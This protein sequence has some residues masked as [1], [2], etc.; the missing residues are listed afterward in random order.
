MEPLFVKIHASLGYGDEPWKITSRTSVEYDLY[1]PTTKR[2]VHLYRGHTY[3][4][5]ETKRLGFEH[6]RDTAGTLGNRLKQAKSSKN[7]FTL[8]SVVI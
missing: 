4:D 6:R 8:L 7:R 1:N 2:R 3:E 5:F